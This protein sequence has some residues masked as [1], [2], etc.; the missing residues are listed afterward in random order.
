MNKKELMNRGLSE[1]HADIV[2][3]MIKDS[4][5]PLYRFNEVNDKMK[6]Y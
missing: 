4:F 2:I 5:V 1:E 3:E 6:S